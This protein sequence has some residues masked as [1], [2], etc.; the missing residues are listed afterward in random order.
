[1]TVVIN[2]NRL[3]EQMSFELKA[4][5]TSNQITMAI[6]TIATLNAASFK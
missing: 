5:S 2:P 6:L 1:M 3:Q 4:K